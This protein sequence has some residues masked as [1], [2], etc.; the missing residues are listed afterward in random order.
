[1][2]KKNTQASSSIILQKQ[3]T[4]PQSQTRSLNES[5]A[6]SMSPAA[7]ASPSGVVA[8]SSPDTAKLKAKN[9]EY[10]QKLKSMVY[11]RDSAMDEKLRQL[12]QAE[13][14]R[15][16]RAKRVALERESKAR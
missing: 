4:R 11:L 7:K 2:I 5:K 10:L 14:L 12:Q 1:M 3:V 9:N 15:E 6:V 13:I 8:S 16:E